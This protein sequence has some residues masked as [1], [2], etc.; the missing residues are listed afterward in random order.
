MLI[1]YLNYLIDKIFKILPLRE[2]I[3]YDNMDMLFKYIDSLAEEMMG[4]Y[5]TF[6]ALNS[7]PEYVSVV[8]TL[9]YLAENSVSVE[10][11]K[12]RVFK[13]IDLIEKIQKDVR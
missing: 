6:E 3:E 12:S 4:A 7:F 5:K 2:D 9:Q 10:K 11:C 8:N 13:M 1:I